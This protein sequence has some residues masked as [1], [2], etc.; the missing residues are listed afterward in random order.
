MKTQTDFQDEVALTVVGHSSIE[1]AEQGGNM[2][3]SLVLIQWVMGS[4]PETMCFS[5]KNKSQK[6]ETEEKEHVK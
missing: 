3:I 6:E 2:Q 4:H 5:L 1:R